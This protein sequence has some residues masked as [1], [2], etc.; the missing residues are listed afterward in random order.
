MG[1]CPAGSARTQSPRTKR[2]CA[3]RANPW[4]GG[5]TVPVPPRPPVVCTVHRKIFKCCWRENVYSNVSCLY[6]CSVLP[7][8]YII[9]QRKISFMKKAQNCDNSLVYNIA[10]LNHRISKL[11]SK[12]SLDNSL[13]VSRTVL[14]EQTC[15]HFVDTSIVNRKLSVF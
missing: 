2:T 14:K 11:M 3:A 1:T 12:Y 4:T 10:T 5:S 15:K 6:Y 7:L 8:L 13:N 9:D